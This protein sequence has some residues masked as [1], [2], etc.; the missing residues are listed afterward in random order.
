MKKLVF[1]IVFFLSLQITVAQDPLFSQFWNAP[2]STNVAN[3]AKIDQF[4]AGLQYRNQWLGELNPHTTY[5][6]HA[7]YPFLRQGPPDPQSGA[8]GIEGMQDVSGLAGRLKTT[9]LKGTYNYKSPINFNHYFTLGVSAGFFSKRID[10][11]SFTTGSQYTNGAFLPSADIMEALPSNSM[12][13]F[14][15]DIGAYYYHRT[16]NGAERWFLGSSVYGVNQPENSFIGGQYPIRVTAQGGFRLME[17][18]YFRLVPQVYAQFQNNSHS[19]MLGANFTY[20]LEGSPRSRST[21]SNQTVGLNIYSRLGTDIIAAVEMKQETFVAGFSY[22]F[23]AVTNSTKPTG[24]FEMYIAYLLP[25]KPKIRKNKKRVEKTDEMEIETSVKELNDS[26]LKEPVRIVSPKEELVIEHLDENVSMVEVRL[27]TDSIRLIPIGSDLV[28]ENL[29][30][31]EQN[32]FPVSFNKDSTAFISYLQ[33]ETNYSLTIIREGFYN[34]TIRFN[35]SKHDSI[36]IPG[37]LKLIVLGEIIILNQVHFES[38]VAVLEKS[39]EVEL[40][41]L[42]S[43]LTEYPTIRA[44]ISGHTDDAG[45]PSYNLELSQ[46]R[47]QVIVDYLVERGIHADRLEAVGFGEKKPIVPNTTIQNKAKNRRVELKIIGK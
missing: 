5:N 40:Q 44:E 12:S 17:T 2:T 1:Y 4:R 45:A 29:D 30:T 38:G 19:T 46:L 3:L 47:A 28:I 8:I 42:I 31:K 22:D 39:S 11:S 14:T 9:S 16:R 34:K 27:L 18:T 33:K 26:I 20:K 23:N 24:S 13:G 6:V 41:S 37:K 32:R 10:A 25:V 36:T 35:T 15:L 21:T 43:F 7:V